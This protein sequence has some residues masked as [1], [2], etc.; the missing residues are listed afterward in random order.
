MTTTTLIKE[1]ILIGNLLTVSR[2]ELMLHYRHG[3]EHGGTQGT[4]A[5]AE[6]CILIPRQQAERDKEIDNEVE[7]T[8]EE[9]RERDWT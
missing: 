9:R 1:N 2:Q 7:R 3:R 4:G 5:V 8:R 6:S